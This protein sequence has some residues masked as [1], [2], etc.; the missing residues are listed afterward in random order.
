MVSTES[1]KQAKIP[2]WSVLGVVLGSPVSVAGVSF[3]L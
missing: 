3:T 1:P 2:D